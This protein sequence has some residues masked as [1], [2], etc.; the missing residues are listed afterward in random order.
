MRYLTNIFRGRL[1]RSNYFLGIL[2][3][4]FL[5]TLVSV[6]TQSISSNINW[7]LAEI[8]IIVPFVL[9]LI[10]GFSLTVRRFHDLGKSGWS[11]FLMLVPLLNILIFLNLYLK[12]GHNSN[13]E[14][15]SEDSSDRL[16][17]IFGLKA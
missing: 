10:F 12:K 14:Y 3:Y 7:I 15:G 4:V 8:I 13:N 6:I 2:L 1:N 17:S 11:L 9:S 5:I 16:R